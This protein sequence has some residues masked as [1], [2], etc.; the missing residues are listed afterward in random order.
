MWNI[1][2]VNEIEMSTREFDESD[3]NLCPVLSLDMPIVSIYLILFEITYLLL[4][5]DEQ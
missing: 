5:S 2:A 3:F 4:P 1:M